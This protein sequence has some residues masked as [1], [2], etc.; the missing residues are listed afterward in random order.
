[1]FDKNNT[2]K[3]FFNKVNEIVTNVHCITLE[4]AELNY[5]NT[6][7]LAVGYYTLHP[8]DKKS[9]VVL[10]NYHQDLYKDKDDE[11]VYLLSRMGA[12]RIRISTSD[13][14]SQKHDHQT[15]VNISKDST[16]DLGAELGSSHKLGTDSKTER[17]VENEGN[18][19]DIDLHLLK[20]SV[21]FKNDGQMTSIFKS[22]IAKDNKLKYYCYKSEYNNQFC[23]D[24]GVAAK[25]LAPNEDPNKTKLEA[26]LRLE[27]DNLK[28]K[29]RYFEVEFH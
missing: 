14:I 8:V 3:N 28:N 1:M 7:N 10:N 17:I 20:N 4:E 5:P 16:I 9:L 27:F 25:F 24:F 15:K 22:R 19:T 23:F 2:Y 11:I 18:I 21:W 26:N 29:V 13:S 6:K 12:K